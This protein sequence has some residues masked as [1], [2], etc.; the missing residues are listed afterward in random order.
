MSGFTSIG[1]LARLIRRYL[2]AVALIAAAL[3][4]V[5]IGL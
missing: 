1:V 5:W 3:C 2:V 4:T